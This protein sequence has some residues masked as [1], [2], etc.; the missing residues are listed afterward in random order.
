MPLGLSFGL[1]VSQLGSEVPGGIQVR[2]GE[3]L[4]PL[5]Q[6]SSSSNGL[7]LAVDTRTGDYRGDRFFSTPHKHCLLGCLL[8]VF[9]QGP[10]W[11]CVFNAP[12]VLVCCPSKGR[13]TQREIGQV[14]SFSPW[15]SAVTSSCASPVPRALHSTHGAPLLDSYCMEAQITW[16]FCY[17]DCVSS[18]FCD[19]GFLQGA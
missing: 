5:L 18:R 1:C 13:S 17:P 9:P 2:D 14:G 3:V 12:V 6:H 16:S 11:L 8:S 15:C 10:S 19:A 7:L 4:S